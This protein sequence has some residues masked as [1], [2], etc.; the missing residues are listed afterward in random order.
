MT[1]PKQL[2]QRPQPKPGACKN[3][4]TGQHQFS[5]YPRDAARCLFCGKTRKETASGDTT[6][7]KD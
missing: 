7:G 6:I 5:G 4:F 2:P 3:S 1:T